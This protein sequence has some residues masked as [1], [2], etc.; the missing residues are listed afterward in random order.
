MHSGR[1]RLYNESCRRP[2]STR[3]AVCAV[4]DYIMLTAGSNMVD[5]FEIAP[6]RDAAA[7]RGA[8]PSFAYAGQEARLLR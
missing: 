6:Q 2:P 1:L 5:V 3:A 4:S 7:Q 8:Q